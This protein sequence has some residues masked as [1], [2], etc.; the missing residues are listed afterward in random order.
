[1]IVDVEHVSKNIGSKEIIHDLSFKLERGRTFALLGPNGA[2][3]TT[4]VR[5]IT[6]L[7][8]PSK[9]Q[10]RLFDME[11]NSKN[12]DILRKKIGVQNDGNLY[13]DLTISQ[14]LNLWGQL[15]EIESSSIKSKIEEILDFFD[16][17]ERVNSKVGQLSKGMRQKVSI[18]RAVFHRPELLILDEPTSGLDPQSTEELISY[19]NKLVENT[20]ISIIMCTHQLQ[21]LEEIADDIGIIQHGN[22]TTFGS[23]NE[24]INNEFPEIIYEIGVDPKNRA[25]E[26]CKKFG[27]IYE[28][29]QNETFRLSITKDIHI[30]QIVKHL[31]ESDMEINTVFEV[32]HT[33]KDAY[34]KI[35]GGMKND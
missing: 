35:V 27:R 22:L 6:G 11:L 3:K 10:I 24:I 28:G 20:G 34:F 4:M 16:L 18:A 12:S 33:I 19:L 14:N 8:K 23:A 9:G 13:E 31:V 1:M 7:L 17:E 25:I 2:G 30:S 5:L 26:E 32:N 21:G 15:Y 29:S